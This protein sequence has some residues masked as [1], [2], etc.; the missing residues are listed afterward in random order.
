MSNQR[1]TKNDKPTLTRTWSI[2]SERRR[3]QGKAKDEGGHN[4]MWG[5]QKDTKHTKKNVAK[6][7]P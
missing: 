7:N 2:G 6:G 1:R 5:R 4:L 3:S